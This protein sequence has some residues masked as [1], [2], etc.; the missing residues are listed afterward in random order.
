MSL[1]SVCQAVVDETG[2]GST[3]ST[4]VG[5]TD[6][7][8]VQLL[9]LAK[10]EINMSSRVANWQVLTLDHT[11]TTV[12]GTESYALP[13]DWSRYMC[14]TFWDAT[15]YWPMRGSIDPQMW[16]A[17]KRGI[18]TGIQTRR[19]FRV[20]GGLV[21]I[22][23]TPTANGNSLIGEYS[24]TNLVVASDGTTLKSTFTVDTDVSR[25]G[26]VLLWTGLKWRVLKAKGLDYSEEKAEYDQQL[27]LKI[28]QDTPG[29]TLNYGPIR[30]RFPM[31]YPNLPQQVS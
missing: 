15:N 30:S 23:P 9:A 1:L 26:E 8:A 31:I 10:R 24:S 13:T 19:D 27:A 6:P 20:K 12:N 11:I 18:V 2:V 22:Y 17:L 4:I 28:A 16:T 21:Y 5:N 29:R 14:N 25:V 7:L 3:P